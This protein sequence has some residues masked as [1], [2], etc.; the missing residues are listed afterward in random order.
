[1]FVSLSVFADDKQEALKAFNS[2]TTAAN[3][4]ST[5]IFSYYSPKAKIIRQVITPD[6]KLV[7]VLTDTSTYITQMK[8]G[9]TGAKIRNYKNNYT[10]VVATPISAGKVKISSVRHPSVD[11]DSLKA[12]MIFQK[13]QNGKWVIIEEMMQTRQ[14]IFLKYAK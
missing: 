10:N 2:Y 5:E 4:Y 1:M 3:N 14:Q 9:Q 8:I 11:N 6:G 7:D 12:Y 13:Q